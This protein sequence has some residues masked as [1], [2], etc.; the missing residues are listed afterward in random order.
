[1]T[2]SEEQYYQALDRLIKRGVRISVDAVAKE[3]GR[4]ASSIRKDRMPRLV[5][6]IN[7]ASVEQEKQVT[8]GSRAKLETKR[9][10]K[11]REELEAYKL[12]YHAVLEKLVSLENQVWELKMENEALKKGKVVS[13]RTSY[14]TKLEFAKNDQYDET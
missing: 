6:D 10:V 14:R 2:K 7:K 11:Y 13:F 8:P 3:A 4:K 1:M 9:K 5:A 12:K